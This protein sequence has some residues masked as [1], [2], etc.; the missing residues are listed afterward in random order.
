MIFWFSK[1]GAFKGNVCRY[2][3]LTVAAAEAGEAG[4]EA[5]AGER[6]APVLVGGRAAEVRGRAAA[7]LEVSRSQEILRVSHSLAA[8]AGATTYSSAVTREAAAVEGVAA[9][10]PPPPP[11]PPAAAAAAAAAIPGRWIRAPASNYVL[12]MPSCGATPSPGGVLA[13]NAYST[14]GS[15]GEGGQVVRTEDDGGEV[16]LYKLNPIDS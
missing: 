3:T 4:V 16:G 9:P 6:G 14:G 15:T 13:G 7:D 8:G 12:S 5:G 10:P 1:L 2:N 11:P